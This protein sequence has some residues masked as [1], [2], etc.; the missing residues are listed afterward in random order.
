MFQ[1]L[2]SA[3]D[4][5][6]V[7]LGVVLTNEEEEGNVFVVVNLFANFGEG[8]GRGVRDVGAVFYDGDF[9]AEAVVAQNL[10]GAVIDRPDGVAFVEE[11]D[12]DVDSGARKD[13]GVGDFEGV[14]VEFAVESGDEGNVEFFGDF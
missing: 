9:A 10:G 1:N 5:V 3:D 11:V 4:A 8:D 2:A 13:F 7:F 14:V 6:E 12:D